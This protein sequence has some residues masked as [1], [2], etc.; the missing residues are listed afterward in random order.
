MS[1]RAAA[2]V[3]CTSLTTGCTVA[4]DAPGD[5]YWDCIDESSAVA[6]INTHVSPD[7]EIEVPVEE[8]REYEWWQDGGRMYIQSWDC[9]ELS[10]WTP[11]DAMKVTQ[12]FTDFTEC[13][14]YEGVYVEYWPCHSTEGTDHEFR[15]WDGDGLSTHDG[16]C[17]DTDPDVTAPV[18]GEACP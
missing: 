8:G 11:T 1:W 16:D 7:F 4:V 5:E 12:V 13:E 15:D 14:L 2:L 10:W 3:A 6:Q 17:D 18:K 9:I